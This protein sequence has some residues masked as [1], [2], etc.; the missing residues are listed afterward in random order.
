MRLSGTGRY[1]RGLE[2]TQATPNQH[3]YSHFRSAPFN[4]SIWLT[5]IALLIS[6]SVVIGDLITVVDYLFR[7]EITPRFLYK[8]ATVFVIAGGVFLYYTA[9]A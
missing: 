4:S 3:F 9:A 6:A 5:Y 2:T 1:S 8:I 7:G